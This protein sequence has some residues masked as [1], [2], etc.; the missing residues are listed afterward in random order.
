MVLPN[1]EDVLDDDAECRQRTDGHA[2]VCDHGVR[3]HAGND[4]TTSRATDADAE[5]AEGIV[6][7]GVHWSG[8]ISIKR[9]CIENDTGQVQ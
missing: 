5:V 1:V 6:E 2:D 9:C 8:L 7:V 3:D 4:E